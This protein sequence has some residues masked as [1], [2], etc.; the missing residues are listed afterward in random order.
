MRDNGPVTQKEFILPE[1][2]TIVSRTDIHGNII[3]ANESFIEASGFAW[4][5]LVGQPHNV[6]RHPDVPPAVFADFWSTIQAGKPWTQIVKNRRKNGD[7]YWVEANATPIYE[8]GQITGFMSVR[9]PAT[10]EQIAQAE[11]AYKAIVDGKLKLTNGIPNSTADNLNPI[12]QADPAIMTSIMGALLFITASLPMFAEGVFEF[13]PKW[14]FEIVNMLLV[15]FIITGAI[16]FGKRL[17]DLSIK[18]TAIS[19]GKFNNHIDTRGT[20]VLGQM[21]SR[22]KSMQIKLGA[23]MDQVKD[24]LATS[25]RIENA[26]KASSSPIVVIDRFGSIIFANVAMQML[27]KKNDKKFSKAFPQFK[28][29]QLIRSNFSVF[30]EQTGLDDKKINNLRETLNT[31]FKVDDLTIDMTIDPILDDK[32]NR[33]GTVTEWKNIT[34]RLIIEKNIE[35][36]IAAAS[37]GS[38]SERLETNN[39]SDFE[40]SI[41]TSMNN[42]LDT[43]SASFT[44]LNNIFSKLADGDLRERM[45]GEYKAELLAMKNS[46]NNALDNLSLTLSQVSSG[47][48]Q[49]GNMAGEISTA[50][51]DLSQ[52][53]QEQAASL[54][55]TS[56]TME[57][58]TS[59][60]EQSTDNSHKANEL[61]QTAGRSASEGIEV[62]NKTLDAMSGITDISKRIGEITSVIDSIAF[63]TN[64]LALNAAVEAARA[65]EHGRGFA[66]VAGEVR[67]LAGKSAE[68]AKD[69]S[70]MINTAIQQIS[71]GT[72][73]VEETNNVFANMVNNIQ[74]V[75][76]LVNEV[77]TTTTEQSKGMHQVNAAVRQLDEVTQQNAALV[78]ELSATAA[79]MSGESSNQAEF[80]KRFKFDDSIT[81]SGTSAVF[82]DA[83][84]K[85]NAWNAKLEQLLTGQEVDINAETARKADACGLGQWIYG[86]GKNY[87]ELAEMQTLEQL[88]AEFHKNVGKVID[89]FAIKDMDTAEQQ[90]KKVCE[91]SIEVIKLIDNVAR[92]VENN[93]IKVKS[94]KV[95]IPPSQPTGKP[96]E[97]KKALPHEQAKP[98][99]ETT[100]LESPNVE[101][102]EVKKP[103]Q[104]TKLQ[105]PPPPAPASDSADEWAEF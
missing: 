6:L 105:V 45:Q 53:T 76:V 74:E 55:Q 84:M 5:E 78:E 18:I 48:Q 67:N 93:G 2:T 81:G 34:E 8:N 39:L 61:A 9:T 32:G 75:G 62:M 22:L 70:N 13:I 16:V 92:Q 47:A 59:T 85:H 1:N 15:A 94:D 7:H 98:K 28:P 80:I 65:G 52:R 56:A 41:S 68:A 104:E 43:F 10:R 89:A 35:D 21:A 38:L 20:N 71:T 60:L 42:L 30:N 99:A 100:R 26:L 12:F 63:Q 83:K 97:S 101:K 44:S 4:K 77:A 3:S 90:K 36:I 17:K 51:E 40:L 69:I 82:T 86:Q 102:L 79:N 58:L 33:I 73:L 91:L 54:E 49:I 14:T 103:T 37:S 25:K 95:I 29:N 11:Q 24:D 72:Q 46:T 64:L 19:E 27:V 57:E 66:V 23:D 96:V 88:H 31:R 50:S 87:M